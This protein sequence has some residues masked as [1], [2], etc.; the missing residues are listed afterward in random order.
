MILETYRRSRD[1]E[2]EFSDAKRQFGIT[3]SERELYSKPPL[4]P[5]RDFLTVAQR[6]SAVYLHDPKTLQ[7]LCGEPQSQS[8]ARYDALLQGIESCDGVDVRPDYKLHW[9]LILNEAAHIKLLT[10]LLALRSIE[11]AREGR[12]VDALDRLTILAKMC[13]CACD[14]GLMLYKLVAMATRVYW[15]LACVHVGF[16]LECPAEVTNS[17]RDLLACNHLDLNMQ[18]CTRHEVFYTLTLARNEKGAGSFVSEGLPKR[19]VNRAVISESIGFFSTLANLFE[20]ASDHFAVADQ[21][22][23]FVARQRPS[24]TRFKYGYNPG[25][26][27]QFCKLYGDDEARRRIGIAILNRKLALGSSAD[28]DSFAQSLHGEPDPYGHGP[29]LLRPEGNRLLVYS[30]GIN[31]LDD[32]GPHYARPSNRGS[33]DVGYVLNL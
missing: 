29:V 25:I 16:R 13:E 32:V 1:L 33:D 28:P 14:A 4:D 6:V 3:E 22:Q 15:Q 19:M 21:G 20:S 23:L 24:L 18:E 17:I 7:L 10:E 8:L 30:K 2:A 26:A 11:L 9:N 5:S 27:G 12:F 31:R